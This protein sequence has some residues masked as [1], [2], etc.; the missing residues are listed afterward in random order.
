MTLNI[1]F[2]SIGV[3][4]I[5]NVYRRDEASL[6]ESIIIKNGLPH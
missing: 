5:M 4:D 6:N 1:I 3:N 2:I